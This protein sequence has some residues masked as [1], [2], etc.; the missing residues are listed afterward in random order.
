MR[1]EFIVNHPS[2]YRVE[3]VCRV[4][5]VSRSGFYAWLKRSQ[6]A[7]KLEDAVLAEEMKKEFKKSHR[8]YG[9]LRTTKRLRARCIVRGKRRTRRIMREHG[10]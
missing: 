7:R 10:L 9:Y 3:K 8:R 6:S 5:N 1:Y 4:L 2:D